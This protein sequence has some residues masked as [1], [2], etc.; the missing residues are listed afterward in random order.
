LDKQ[1]N[2]ATG[3]KSAPPNKSALKCFTI[4]PFGGWYDRYYEE[5]YKPAI[6]AAGLKPH[7]ADDLNRPSSIINDIWDLT[8]GARVLLADLTGRN[9]NV[10]YELGLAHAIA[11]PV[12]L[13]ADSIES[14]PFDLRG[15]RTLI[16]DRNAPDWGPTL[17]KNIEKSL[18]EVLE[19]P[20]SGVPPTFLKVHAEKQ[21]TVSPHEK[22]ILQIRADLDALKRQSAIFAPLNLSRSDPSPYLSLAGSLG[23][24]DSDRLSGIVYGG[25][26]AQLVDLQRTG[27]LTLLS[28]AAQGH[29]GVSEKP[30]STGGSAKAGPAQKE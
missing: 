29:S 23:V 5:V 2:K 24:S 4:M 9:P 22:E 25:T 27:V 1:L 28:A 12:V 14:V 17:S 21:P 19:S 10:F 11:K 13:V 15:L 26:A 16:Y 30:A 7:R 6:E 20:E 3:T 18:R 8:R